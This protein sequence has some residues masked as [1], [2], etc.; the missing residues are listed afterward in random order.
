MLAQLLRER[1]SRCFKGFCCLLKGK[2]ASFVIAVVC[3]I[4]FLLKFALICPIQCGVVG[5]WECLFRSKTNSFYFEWGSSLWVYGVVHD[6]DCCIT[7]SIFFPAIQ[8]KVEFHESPFIHGSN[9]CSFPSPCNTSYGGKCGWNYFG[10][11][12]RRHQN[13]LVPTLQFCP[14]ILCQ[15]DQFLGH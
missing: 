5:S 12:K 4:L 13:N 15:F 6:L 14:R 10:P 11:C 1:S 2:W 9:S 8:G 7:N 3:K